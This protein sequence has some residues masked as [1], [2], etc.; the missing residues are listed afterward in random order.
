MS[1]NSWQGSGF[2]NPNSKI[3]VRLISR[4]GNDVFDYG[5]WKRRIAY[6]IKYRKTV[7]PGDDFKCCRLV[8]GE[9]DQLPGL[10]VDRYGD[11]LSWR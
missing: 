7:M 4:N 6:S 3:T 2:Y 10:T 1:G 5:F 8:H 11:I 9:A